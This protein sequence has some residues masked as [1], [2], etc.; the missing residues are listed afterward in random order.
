MSKIILP[1]GFWES[2]GKLYH[3]VCQP[4]CDWIINYLKNDK[5][6]P[7]YDFGC[8]NG[9]YLNEFYNAGFSNLTGFEG[10]I[11]VQKEFENI[12]CQ[13]LTLSFSV[14]D[15]GNCVFLEVAE[16]IPS[17]YENIMLDNVIN[18]CNDKLIMSWAIIGQD[19]DGHVNCK[20]NNDVVKLLTSKGMKYLHQETIDARNSI[21]DSNPYG[22][23]KTNTFI[24][25]K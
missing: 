13:D 22:W 11:P 23:F 18:A 10:C 21:P 19:G 1:T 17:K 6:K 9:H 5:D 2:E 12:I 7:L 14:A 16:H 15:K 3:V 4:L 24:F 20:N 8:G 25:E